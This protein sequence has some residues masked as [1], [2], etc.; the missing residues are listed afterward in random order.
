MGRS[1]LSSVSP[2]RGR[3]RPGSSGAGP[4]L[5]A[6][7]AAIGLAL[8]LAPAA[9]GAQDATADPTL[10][11]AL[12][13]QVAGLTATAT[14]DFGDTETG[15]LQVVVDITNDTGA[16]APVA[17]PFGTLLATDDD[18]DQ[19]MAVGGPV[20]DPTLALVAQAGGT[21]VLEAPPGASTHE[22]VVYCSEAD[23][24]AP[25][26][27]TPLSYLGQADE[28]LPAVLRAVAVQQ[29]DPEVAQ[30][31][32]WWVTDDATDPV[33]TALAPL[34]ADVDTEAFAAEPHRVVP[35]TGYTPR[36]ARAG[37]LDESFESTSSSS[38]PGTVGGA[39]LGALIWVLAAVAAVIAAVIITSRS[40]RERPVPVSTTQPAGWYPDP[41]SAGQQRWWDGRAWTSRVTGRS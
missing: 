28:P 23:D 24:T 41:W 37:I 22:L 21:P 13:G 14:S 25:L 15:G 1:F 5:L 6:L 35:H 9:A 27:P 7:V 31:A 26:E 39:G 4:R 30:D 33:P 40:A 20:D 32:V 2:A 16:P 17:V 10:G 29:P 3:A 36:W 34:L 11:A 12:D 8:L 18:A 19:T 38:G